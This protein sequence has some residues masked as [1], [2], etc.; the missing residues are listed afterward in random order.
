MTTVLE[1][2]RS[3]SIP[4]PGAGDATL[5]L[6]LGPCRLRMVAGDGPTWIAG[7]YEDRVNVLPIDVE[8]DGATATISQRFGPTSFVAVSAAPRLDLT[9]DR[10]RPFSLV[11]ETGAG[12][13]AIDVGGLPIVAFE[14]KAGAGRYELDVS[15]PNPAEMR[16]MEL[17]TGA[18]QLIARRLANANFT[19]LRVGTGMAGCA[20][21]LSGRL[22]RDA[23]VRIDA[24]LA[25][26]DLFVPATTAMRLRA[27]S[28]AAGIA[29]TGPVSRDGDEYR[30]PAATA[31]AHPLLSVEASLALGQLT[32]HA[33]ERG[34]VP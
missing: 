34:E 25:S 21:D 16:S 15:A 33:T 13:H 22:E 23:S 30:T 18:G 4:Y 9:I 19:T 27:K 14:L 2:T 7:S 17:A 24:G 26:I 8:V 29:V 32:I 20:V 28:F 12:D 1:A 3:I 31:G 6:R 5:K 11:I 10:A